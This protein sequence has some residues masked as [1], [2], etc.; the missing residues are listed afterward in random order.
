M[1]TCPDA[2]S[3]GICDAEDQC[4][5]L[6]DALIGTPC[7]DGNACTE[8]DVYGTDCNCTS[9]LIDSNNNN[10]C[11]LD[12]G[13]MDPNSLQAVQVSGTSGTLSWSAVPNANS[14]RLQYRPIGGSPVS[15]DI[16]TS[17]YT[18]NNLSPGS[19]VQWRV[20][21]LCNNANSGFVIGPN[22]NIG[23]SAM[24]ANQD[25]S[26]PIFVKEGEDKADFKLFPNPAGEIVFLETNRGEATDVT[27]LSLLG[28]ELGRYRIIGGQKQSLNT[29][30]WGISQQVVLIRITQEGKKPVTRRLLLMN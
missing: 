5:G 22:L 6:D 13:C 4:P 28:Q 16:N 14:Y 18:V 30:D 1:D 15:L 26:Q 3:D 2:D 19:I 24:A 7:D 20:K 23:G 10:I 21:A 25:S 8:N 17:D 29:T 12:E 11:D 9:M 27:V